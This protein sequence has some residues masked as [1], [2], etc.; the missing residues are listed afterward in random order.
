MHVRGFRF[1]GSGFDC[2]LLAY[3]SVV[4]GFQLPVSSE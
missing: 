1:S 4:G 3:D 2:A